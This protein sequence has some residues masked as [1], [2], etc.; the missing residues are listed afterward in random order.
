MNVVM[1]D[2]QN[3]NSTNC[4]RSSWQELAPNLGNN[5]SIFHINMR[6]VANK[7]S[8]LVAYLNMLKTKFT[9]IVLTETWLTDSSDF[10][11]EIDGYDSV[12]LNRNLRPGGGLKIFY[13]EH[14]SVEIC[15]SSYISH[16][17]EKM[18]LKTSIPSF[19][20]LILCALYRPPSGS[21]PDFCEN[22]SEVLGNFIDSRCVVIGDLNIN[23]LN[24]NSDNSVR[25]YVD[26]FS[27][28]GFHNQI[29]LPTYHSP[30]TQTDLSCLDHIFHNL[31]MPCKGFVVE[32]RLAD[33]YGTCLIID[34]V[35]SFPNRSIRFRDFSQSNIENFKSNL[36]LEC[37]NYFPP[38][39]D[40]ELCAQYLHDYLKSLLEKYFP[41]RC[42]TIS[43]KRLNSPWVTKNIL[44]C[45]K[46]KHRWYRLWKLGRI[47]KRS[48]TR[49]AADVRALMRQAE[50]HY[51]RNKLRSL[52]GDSRRNWKVLNRLIKKSSKRA[53]SVFRI[54]DEAI[55]DPQT[56]S[57]AFIQHFHDKPIRVSDNIPDSTFDFSNLIGRNDTSMSIDLCSPNEVL[58]II[59]G[60]KKTGN[61]HDISIRF[62]KLGGMHFAEILSNFYN[63]CIANGYFPNVFKVSRITPVFKKGSCNLIDNYRPVSV[64]CNLG[65]IFEYMLF[66]RLKQF[67]N[68]QNLLSEK[69]YGFRAGKSTE[70]A[71]F[72]LVWKILPAIE[73]KMYAVCIF[74]DFSICFDTIDRNILLSKLDKYG[75]RGLCYDLIKSYFNDRQQFVQFQN[76]NSRSVSQTLG[77]VQGSRLGPLLFDIYSNDFN[78]LCSRDENILYADDTCLIYVGDDLQLLTNHVNMRLNI[79]NEWCNSNKLYV[80]RDKSEYMVITNRDMSSVPDVRIGSD[81][82]NL[83]KHFKYL[84]INI[85]DSCKFNTHI[86]SLKSRL[87][88]LRGMSYRLRNHLDIRAAKQLYYSCV[89][90]VAMYGIAVWGGAL[91]CNH[92]ADS[93]IRLQR[94]ILE[95]LFSKFF[96]DDIN[97]HAKILKIEDVYRL[98]VAIYMFRILVLN[99]LPILKR[100]LLL[101][102]APHTYGTRN[103]SDLRLPYPRTEVIRLSYK[104]Q[105]VNVWNSIP[106]RIRLLPS[107][108]QFK[109]ALTDHFL[110]R[111]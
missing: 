98:R 95:N 6:S 107:L 33:H 59:G 62:L 7:F 63:K 46:K 57:D 109:R 89:Y 32:P 18:V 9:F 68:S 3:I 13:L 96:S 73:Q 48:Y 88:S 52:S 106:E 108:K 36:P 55:S 8:E 54:N 14:I 22:M 41:I 66:S 78:S 82:L 58:N 31:N 92:R 19:G 69:Q 64:L 94:H 53:P 51:Y 45:I 97:F 40:V 35:T 39:D 21:I 38:D 65:K 110:S 60:L 2:A 26:M 25:N 56:I 43:C 70:L 28:Y 79:I 27:E 87:S 5:V 47:E 67:F 76:C 17:S 30:I 16:W 90:S 12:S 34:K 75:V 93:L 15:T 29:N 111:Y 103:A 37:S 20:N 71:V 72:D 99:E 100:C 1:H 91:I 44:K 77:V 101:S 10:G 84:G 85:D 42:K 104:Y 102:Q 49:L 81:R 80:N 4:C 86:D 23:L 50:E 61:I 24:Y 83:V 105:F 11:Y 74:L